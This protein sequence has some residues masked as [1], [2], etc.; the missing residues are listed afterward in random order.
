M[1]FNMVGLPVL[2]LPDPKLVLGLI[3]SDVDIRF[4]L[5]IDEDVE[6]DED[7]TE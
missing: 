1:L 6:E 7:T 2:R 3:L 4:E 5:F